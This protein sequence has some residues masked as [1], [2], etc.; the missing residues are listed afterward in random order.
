MSLKDKRLKHYELFRH[1]LR[2]LRANVGKSATDLSKDL[3]CTSLKRINDLEEGRVAEP[4]LSEV[5]AIAKYFNV[6]IDD[7]LYK[8]ADIFFNNKN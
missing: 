1:N 4:N 7:I 3:K 6:S 2:L 5:I 8:K